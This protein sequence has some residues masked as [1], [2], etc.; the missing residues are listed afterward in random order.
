MKDDDLIDYDDFDDDEDVD[1]EEMD[2]EEMDEEDEFDDDE[3]DGSLG[4]TYFDRASGAGREPPSR[5][6]AG[7]RNQSRSSS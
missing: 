7:L 1:D 4:E 2:D 6:T 5:N 3:D